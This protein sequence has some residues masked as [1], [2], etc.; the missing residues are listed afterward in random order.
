L[1]A[2]ADEYRPH[3]II[4]ED[5][6]YQRALI[7]DLGHD[8]LPVLGVKPDGDKVARAARLSGP[9][10]AGKVLFAPTVLTA[11]FI[12]EMTA[13]PN[14]PYDD[15]VDAAGYAVEYLLHRQTVSAAFSSDFPTW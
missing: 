10:A 1:R 15:R 3:V 7:T 11:D 14:W 2:L 6:A 8:G 12:N 13:F 5:V 9:L 4:V